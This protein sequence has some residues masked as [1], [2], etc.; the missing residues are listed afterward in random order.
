MSVSEF[1]QTNVVTASRETSVRDVVREMADRRVGSVVVTEEGDVE[2]IVTDRQIAL[3]LGD[4]PDVA[5]A[6][7]SDVMTDDPVTVPESASF[8]EVVQKFDEENVR[9]F[10]VVEDGA[11]LVGV[12][13]LD[14]VLVML[15]TEFGHAAD[16]IESQSPR[17]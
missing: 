3:A 16:V 14:D 11:A 17:F 4:D 8:F 5:K 6:D 12:V 1:A 13:S 7:V 2:G 10:P 15:A 9:R